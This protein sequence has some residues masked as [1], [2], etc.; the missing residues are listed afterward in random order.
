MP[1]A[2]FEPTIAASE[3][4]PIH[5]IDGAATGIGKVHHKSIQIAVPEIPLLLCTR[6][7]VGS[8]IVQEFKKNE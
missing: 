1:P 6:I 4:P 8:S 7:Y 3:R 2:G 5:A